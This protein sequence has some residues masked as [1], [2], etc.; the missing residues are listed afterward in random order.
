MGLSGRRPFCISWV[1][2]PCLTLL[3]TQGAPGPALSQP[4]RG[5]R[6]LLCP[7]LSGHSTLPG[8]PGQTP[9]HLATLGRGRNAEGIQD[10]SMRAGE[11]LVTRCTLASFCSWRN[12]H[13]GAPFTAE[14]LCVHQ[15][16]P[17]TPCLSGMQGAPCGGFMAAGRCCVRNGSSHRGLRGHQS[18][19]GVLI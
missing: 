12:S 4:G 1:S 3:Q 18:H 2:R 5:L 14:E 17:G 6:A 10:D 13:A 7:S 9:R 15:P 11:P 19:W 16:L 8:T